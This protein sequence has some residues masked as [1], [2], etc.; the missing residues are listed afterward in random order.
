MKHAIWG[1]AV[2][3]A[4]LWLLPVVG[5]VLLLGGCQAKEQPLS[6]AAQA[7]RGE[8]LG[9]M[10][11]L[12]AALAAPLAHQDREAV[13]PIL[14]TASAA[15][16]KKGRLVPTTLAVLD[17]NGITQGRFPG[18]DAGHLD[19][20]NYDATKVVYKE[21]RIAQAR[22]FLGGAKIFVVL[23]PVLKQDQVIGAV[24]LGFSEEDL[25]KGKI[26]EKDF[27]DLDFNK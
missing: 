6:T 16:E 25:R 4:C 9:E 24:A 19:F 10:H 5:L 7:F 12:T 20:M 22:L 2:R 17:E 18:R 13:R 1:R 27:L 15:M 21:K 14:Q 8:V 11:K 23:A 26:S 3:P